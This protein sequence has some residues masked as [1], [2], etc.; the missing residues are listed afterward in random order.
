ME[1]TN[2]LCRLISM[3]GLS[4]SIYADQMSTYWLAIAFIVK[5]LSKLE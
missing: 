3:D 2:D 1:L 4:G 5:S